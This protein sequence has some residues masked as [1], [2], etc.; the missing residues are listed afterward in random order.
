[1]I[2]AFA[3]RITTAILTTPFPLTNST[4]KDVKIS[5]RSSWVFIS[6]I[7]NEVLWL[8][9]AKSLT[10]YTMLPKSKR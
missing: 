9:R 10:A 8:F 2:L 6:G 5:G 4:E 7:F 1:M 3:I